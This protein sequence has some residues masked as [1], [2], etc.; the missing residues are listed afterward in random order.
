[1]NPSTICPFSGFQLF[2]VDYRG[3][4]GLLELSS[5]PVRWLPRALG[6]FWVAVSWARAALSNPPF[7]KDLLNLSSQRRAMGQK[8]IRLLFFLRPSRD[9]GFLGS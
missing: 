9:V 8:V 6:M 4:G 5:A 3:L 7:F 1:M 2:G